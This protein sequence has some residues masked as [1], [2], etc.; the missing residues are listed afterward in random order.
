MF[1][2]FQVARL[3]SGRVG[4][5]GSDGV[6]KPTRRRHSIGACHPLNL[7]VIDAYDS[8]PPPKVD[9]N[10]LQIQSTVGLTF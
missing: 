7:N 8:A 5:Y 6:R 3:P 1:P 2:D 4:A 9:P 10:D